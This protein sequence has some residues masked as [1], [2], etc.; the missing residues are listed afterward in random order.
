M[1]LSN[2]FQG[3]TSI[4]ITFFIFLCIGMLYVVVN[5]LLRRKRPGSGPHPDKNG[6]S[7]DR[8]RKKKR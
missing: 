5:H 4:G 3:F 8:K 7:R 2:G 1:S 6:A